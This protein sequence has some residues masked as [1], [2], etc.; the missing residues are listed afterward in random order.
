MT[1]IIL[2]CNFLL[3]SAESAPLQTNSAYLFQTSKLDMFQAKILAFLPCLFVTEHLLPALFE[4]N[5]CFTGV[6]NQVSLPQTASCLLSLCP[7][8]SKFKVYQSRHFPQST[9]FKCTLLVKLNKVYQCKFDKHCT[10]TQRK[11]KIGWSK[12][13]TCISRASF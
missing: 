7:L 8:G 2:R 1:T 9:W 10:H 3:S 4:H 11:I 6:T 13:Y 12:K 5:W